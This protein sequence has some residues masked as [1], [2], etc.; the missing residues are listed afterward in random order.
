MA[1]ARSRSGLRNYLKTAKL[2]GLDKAY[3]NPTGE[4]A[5]DM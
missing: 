5:V 1:P 4:A 2:I 3:D